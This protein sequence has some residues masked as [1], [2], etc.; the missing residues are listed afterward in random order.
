MSVLLTVLAGIVATAT[1]VPLA[2]FCI[3]TGAGLLPSR[4][5]KLSAPPPSIAVL[6]PA[7]NEE[8]GITPT[9]ENLFQVAPRLTRVV[10]VADNCSD[11]TAN[12]A[13]LAGAEVIER[14]DAERRG[15][16]YALAFG[17][18]YLA[19]NN[20]PEVVLVLDAD[21]R[22]HPGSAEALA[23][24]AKTNR[25]PAQAINLISPDLSAPPMVQIS[26]F[27]MLVK[28]LFRSRGMQ[29]MG[30]AALLTGTGMAF[31]WSIYAKAD[32]ATGSIVEDLEFGIAT[33][34]QGFPPLLVETANVRSAPAAMTDALQQRKRWEHGFLDVLKNQAVPLLLKGLS[35]F[36]WTEIL[37]GAHLIVPP[38]ALLMVATL[39]VIAFC[40][41]LFLIGASVLPVMLLS[42]L[43][44]ITGVLVFLAW[45]A[46]GREFLSGQALLRAPLYI[47][48]KLPMY[49]SFFRSPE[50]TWSRTRRPDE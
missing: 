22:L 24:A 1:A 27:A 34:R 50:A 29:R 7:H 33:T 15:K 16:G 38:L 45:L 21:C 9:L 46:K 25:R 8:G 18:D 6:V 31:P 23:I 43:F 19:A 30:G 49:L 10:V 44:G 4:R 17:R 41:V 14:N 28:N 5:R 26:G 47:L 12:R 20:P 2:I 42:I 32:L 39:G 48:W 13:R 11:A 36:R 3:E 40:G 37:L 35:R